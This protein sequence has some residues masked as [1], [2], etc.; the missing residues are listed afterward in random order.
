MYLNFSWISRAKHILRACIEHATILAKAAGAYKLVM[1]LQRKTIKGKE[2]SFETFVAGCLGGY[3]AFKGK[4]AVCE[5]VCVLSFFSI[6]V[7][8]M[9]S[10]ILQ[11]TLYI[12]SRAIAALMPRAVDAVAAASS[13]SESFKA[14]HPDSRYMQALTALSWG[15]AMWLFRHHAGR[16]QPGLLGSIKY[17]YM[18]LGI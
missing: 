5:Q 18:D 1:L 7:P 10:Q 16:L 14:S 15:M 11:I 12:A 13:S 4:S 17:I 9:R 2:R 6:A 3:V 8:E